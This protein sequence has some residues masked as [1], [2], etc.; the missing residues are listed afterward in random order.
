MNENSAKLVKKKFKPMQK[1]E[2]KRNHKK[3]IP[4]LRNGSMK[5]YL[6]KTN[7]KRKQTKSKKKC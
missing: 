1:C 5:I 6:F 2:E 3:I 4:N 7:K